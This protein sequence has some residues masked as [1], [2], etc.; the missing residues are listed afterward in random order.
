MA[1]LQG[2]DGRFFNIDDEIVNRHEIKR[3]DLPPEA[4]QSVLASQ[5]DLG[6]PPST[7]P[8]QFVELVIRIPLGGGNPQLGSSVM[9]G[10]PLGMWAQAPHWSN[11][12]NDTPPKWMNVNPP[13]WQ[14]R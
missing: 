8:S 4:Q 2:L 1:I 6:P 11:W 3:E 12:N 7:P 13:G 5:P 14:N 10:I 9:G